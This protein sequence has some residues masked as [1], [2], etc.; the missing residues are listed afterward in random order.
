MCYLHP[1]E[2][3]LASKSK[4]TLAY[5]TT[6]MDL[7]D[8]TL[9]EATQSQRGKYCMIPLTRGAQRDHIHTGRKK[10]SGCHRL[11]RRGIGSS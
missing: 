6:E 7:E 11:E 8:I 1:R 3:H 4:E 9:S 10:N 5:A 2:C